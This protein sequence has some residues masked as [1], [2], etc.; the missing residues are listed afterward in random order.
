MERRSL[1]SQD[2]EQVPEECSNHQM[3]TDSD[4]STVPMDFEDDSGVFMD[5]E[6][7]NLADV[8]HSSLSE[9][10]LCDVNSSTAL[11]VNEKTLHKSCQVDFLPVT[12]EASKTFICNMFPRAK[13][14]DVQVQTEISYGPGKQKVRMKLKVKDACCGSDVKLRLLDC[15]TQTV[16]TE[17]LDIPR[18]FLGMDSITTDA[19]LSELAGVSFE[20]FRLFEKIMIQC[21]PIVRKMTIANRVL[22]FLCKMKT[23]L[24]YSALGVLFS[25]H[26]TTISRVFIE[27]LQYL[28]A[29]TQNFIMWPNKTVIQAT[30]PSSFKPDYKDCRIIIDCTEFSIEMPSTVESR[31]YTYSHYKH[32][33]TVKVLIACSPSGLIVFKSPCYGGRTSD[34]QVTIDSG[35]LDKLGHGDLVLADKGFPGIK[36]TID[37]SGKRILLVMPPFLE[38]GVFTKQEVEETYKI[39]RVRIHIE[40]IMQRLRLYNI[41]SKIPHHLIPYSDSIVHICCV[42]VN[43]QAPIIAEVNT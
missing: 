37:Q 4:N 11:A 10:H 7:S 6:T 16:P 26:R 30:M 12:Q 21:C 25:V 40:R 35:L 39:A 23:G 18:G 31:V 38:N 3:Q 19:E 28:T 22:V 14:C 34:T 13:Q 20:Q 42:L 36:S 15:G 29:A 27:T 17:E 8:T 5:I 24:D 33:F 9:L 2:V 1:T 41:L 32:Q 43:L